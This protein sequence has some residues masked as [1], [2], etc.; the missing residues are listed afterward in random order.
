MTPWE[1]EQTL[2]VATSC[3]DAAGVPTFALTEVAL[4]YD[5][6]ANGGHCDLVEARLAEAGYSEPFLHFDEVEAP[7]FLVP[8]VRAYFGAPL[9][10]RAAQT[11]Q[12]RPEDS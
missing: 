11:P 1:G 9:S 2:A 10:A 7:P 12:T 8:A 3:L 6:Y 5:A 4:T